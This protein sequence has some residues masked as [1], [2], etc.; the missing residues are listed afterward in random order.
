MKTKANAIGPAWGCAIS[1]AKT[2]TIVR[3]SNLDDWTDL[4]PI[5]A[6]T[7]RGVKSAMRRVRIDAQPDVRARIDCGAGEV[8]EVEL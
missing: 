8:Y 2:I 5:A 1:G 6:R 4:G 7:V 3:R